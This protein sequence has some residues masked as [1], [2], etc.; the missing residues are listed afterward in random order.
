MRKQNPKKA[1]RD[2]VSVRQRT[3]FINILRLVCSGAPPRPSCVVGATKT[4]ARGFSYRLPKPKRE[5]ALRAG[6]GRWR[7]GASESCW[8]CSRS[9]ARWLRPL[10]RVM[11]SLGPPAPLCIANWLPQGASKEPYHFAPW[12]GVTY[13]RYG[14]SVTGYVSD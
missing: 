6:N 13:T 1:A 8:C 10:G 7:C 9:A 4:K 5:G 12:R 2:S 3:P 11:D 14:V